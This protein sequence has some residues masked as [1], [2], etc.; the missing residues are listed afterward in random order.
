MSQAHEN[1][2]ECKDGVLAGLAGGN[3]TEKSNSEKEKM[4]KNNNKFLIIPNNCEVCSSDIAPEDGKTIEPTT[5][6]PA[7][8]TSTKPSSL[9]HES[10]PEPTSS[11]MSTGLFSPSLDLRHSTFIEDENE[12]ESDMKPQ[13][14]YSDGSVRLRNPHIELMDQ[15]ILYHLALGSES[16]DLIEMFQDI[17]FVCIGGTPK[18]MEEFAYFI[19]REIGH[20]IPT[21]T[22]LLDISQ[23]SYRYSMYKVGPV[24]SVSHG[25]GIPSVSILLHEVIKL[26][27]HAKARDPVFFRIGTC[28]GI[29]IDGGNVIIT[30]EAL[31]SELKPYH[32]I[33][34]LGK[35]IRRPSK[36]DRRLREDLL[37]LAHEKDNAYD[38]VVGKTMCTDDFYEGQA[39]LD[40]CICEYSEK[41]K[42]SYLC[43]LNRN[44]V[45]NIEMESLA[46]AA[47][48]HHAGVRAAVVCVS[49]LDRLKG[50]QVLAAKEVLNEWQL[51][52]QILIAQYIKKELG[53]I[54]I[55][56]KSPIL[57][58]FPAIPCSCPHSTVMRVK[59]PRR[60]NMVQQESESYD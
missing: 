8:I 58:S 59:S 37:S 51:R 20:K 6:E 3:G 44:G 11:E 30:E 45:T 12:R 40:G 28:G 1:S 29:G 50:D 43:E 4:D 47:L 15:D 32:E 23:Y 22:Q 48:T 57:S 33:S 24:L 2:Q 41:E 5:V 21:G 39:R 9:I 19:M 54:P 52:P 26:M 17:K 36:L 10:T 34:V 14:R 13:T 53:L 56:R 35:K 25:M 46:F 55:Q 18:R 27:Y 16:H 31:N 38:T 60:M 42:M 49:L 7:S